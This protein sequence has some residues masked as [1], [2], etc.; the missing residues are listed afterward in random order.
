MGQIPVDVKKIKCDFLSTTG[1]KYLR[2]PRGTGFLFVSDRMLATDCAPLFVDMRGAD[3]TAP[4]NYELQKGARRFETW[5]SPYALIIGLKE[6]IRICNRVD[7]DSIHKQ[8]T[9]VIG[10]LRENLFFPIYSLN[11]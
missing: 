5:E 3:W 8:N 11:V 1:R 4:D 6:A 10:R 9:K 2:G 7:I